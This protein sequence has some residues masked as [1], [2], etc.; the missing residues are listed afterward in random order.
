MEGTQLAAE[1][2]RDAPEPVRGHLAASQDLPTFLA[3][4]GLLTLDDRKRLVDQALVLMEQNYVHLP[5]KVA[6]HA[7]NP[8]QRLR[9]LRTRLERQTAETMDPEWMFH[10]ELSRTFHSVRDLHTNYI[11]PLPFSGKM[12][13]LPFQVEEYFDDHRSSRYLVSRLMQGFSA[14]QLKHADVTYWNGVPILDEYIFKILPDDAAAVNQLKTGL[15]TN[16]R[17]RTQEAVEKLMTD[18]KVCTMLF[19][20]GDQ[21][22]LMDSET[23]EQFT[24][25]KALAG[26]SAVF[27]TEGMEVTL[28]TVEGRPVALHLPQTV[29]LRITEADAVVKGQT[30][31]S[32]YKPAIL[33]N[34]VKIMVPPHVESGSF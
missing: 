31:S 12:A 7:V 22:T 9:L 33:E 15:K 20:E 8:V 34:G 23:F 16:L 17:F 5:L 26:D 25:E 27:L 28:D 18:E 2:L 6:M 32:S 14:P 30:A 10:A 4:A 1:F 13:F 24:V 3:G 11:L 29:T 19:A 21:I